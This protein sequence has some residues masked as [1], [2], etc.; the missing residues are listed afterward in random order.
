MD[1]NVSAG[2]VYDYKVTILAKSIKS[3][4][5]QENHSFYMHY[6]NESIHVY[7]WNELHGHLI[8]YK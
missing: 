1:L 3:D 8:S 2:G 5:I 6:L 4:H 7:M